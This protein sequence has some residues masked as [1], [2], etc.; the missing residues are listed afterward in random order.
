[1]LDKALGFDQ[2]APSRRRKADTVSETYLCLNKDLQKKKKPLKKSQ[3][4]LL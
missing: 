4:L 3:N 1:M 2:P